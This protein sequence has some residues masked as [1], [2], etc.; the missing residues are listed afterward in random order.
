MVTEPLTVCRF[1]NCRTV[2]EPGYADRGLCPFHEQTGLDAI[3]RLPLIYAAL[4]PLVWDKPSALRHDTGR[5]NAVFGPTDP[6]RWD[7]DALAGEIEWA[8]DTWAEIVR[9]RAR[10]ADAT[11]LDAGCATL[12]AHYAVLVACPPVDV[13]DYDRQLVTMDGP[14]AVVWLTRL[15]RRGYGHT[16]RLEREYVLPEPCWECGAEDLR[17]RDSRDTVW[18]GTC[19]N[20]WTWDQYQD[21]TS[22]LAALP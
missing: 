4:L 10:L 5:L 8:V 22:L 21:A 3:G 12:A 18:C 7:I 19:R 9:D 17:H 6:G 14:D 15:Y 20:R 2:P 13:V 1:T 16:G 11:G